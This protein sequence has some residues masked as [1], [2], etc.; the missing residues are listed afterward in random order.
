[1]FKSA[2]RAQI[3]SRI[4]TPPPRLFSS[5]ATFPSSLKPTM[6]AQTRQQQ[7]PGSMVSRDCP[8]Q[9]LLTTANSN[10]RMRLP[11]SLMT[12]PGQILAVVAT[13]RQRRGRI[14]RAGYKDKVR[15]F[16]PFHPL[17]CPP[18]CHAAH[19]DVKSFS[20]PAAAV[21]EYADPGWPAQDRS[22]WRPTMMSVHT[23]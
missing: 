17:T 4:Q 7:Q 21:H 12:D 20:S 19:D 9:L 1:V 10:D 14:W 18:Q 22:H 13:T 15:P 2:T 11:G 6:T 16:L 5:T 8:S 23:R 3:N